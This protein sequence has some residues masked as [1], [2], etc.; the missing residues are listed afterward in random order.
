MTV[1]LVGLTISQVEIPAPIVLI[2]LVALT[3][4]QAF[5]M[6]AAA[7]IISTQTTS[8]RAAN[9]L[10]SFIVIPSALLIQ[11]ESI[12]VFW[13]DFTT[14]WWAVFGMG[15]FAILLIRVGMAHFR[16]EELLG[17]EIDVL[18]FRWGWRIFKSAF[19][20]HSRTIGEWYRSV[21]VALKKLL[22]PIG[23]IT[24]L[25]GI[26]VFLGYQQSYRFQIPLTDLGLDDIPGRISSILQPI[27]V[28]DFSPIWGYFWN[29]LRVPLLGLL[30]GFFSFGVFV[31]LP[32]FLSL[33]GV[34]YLMGL[35]NQVGMTPWVYLVAFILPHGIFEIP[36]AILATASIFRMG[37]KLA[38][39]D[40]HKT[41]SEIWLELFGEWAKVMVGIVIPLLILAAF[42][43]A[44]IT[45]RIA[46]IIIK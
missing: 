2:Q 26:A 12:V 33:G 23:I 7:V 6:V 39:P 34:G 15:V 14:L 42:A 24:L 20:S 11:A 4:V 16:R 40:I 36:A 18:N 17:K 1:Y 21:G 19:S 37:A 22:I 38:Y 30:L 44:W 31:V 9:L 8:V 41:V 32:V 25:L 10:A 5:V 3:T 43:E 29:N 27:P 45:P 46:L 28:G 35:L 13:G